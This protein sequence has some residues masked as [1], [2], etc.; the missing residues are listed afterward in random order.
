MINLNHGYVYQQDNFDWVDGIFSL[1][2]QAKEKDYL[3]IV[4]TN[5]SGIGRGMYSEAEFE[6]LS[7]W[8]IKEAAHHNALIDDVFYCPHHP[9]DAKPAYLQ[10]CECRKPSPGMLHEAAQLWR[11]D[12]S[13]SVMVGDK[14]IDMQCAS[15]A[16]LLKGYL[17]SA[18]DKSDAAISKAYQLSI[19]VESVSALSNIVLP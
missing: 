7:H 8:M 19:P 15:R 18:L 11:I 5:Q 4:V 9:S 12:L 10:Y 6:S 14:G 16:G 3:V 2:Q 1:I 13:K 17:F